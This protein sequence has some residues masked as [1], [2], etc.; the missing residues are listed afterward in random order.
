MV[1]CRL[2]RSGWL[3]LFLGALSGLH[4]PGFVQPPCA[5]LGQQGNAR[6]FC[7]IFSKNRRTGK[8]W[9]VQRCCFRWKSAAGRL[10][11]LEIMQEGCVDQYDA[12]R[13][14]E[15]WWKQHV[16]N[17]ESKLDVTCRHCGHRS[18]STTL[19]S[20]QQGRSPGCF[21]NG[22]VP[23]SGQAGRARCLAILQERHGD[24]YDASRMDEAW[25]KQYVV[26]QLSKLDVTCRRCGHRS[27][28]TTLRSLQQDRS[29]GCFCN[30]AVPWSSL[31]GRARFLEILQER[32]G[33]Q[34]D[35]SRMDEAWWKQHVVN[36]QSKLDVTC[37]HCGHRSISTTLQSL[38][39]DCSP[40]CFCNGGVPWSGQAGRAR[41]LEILQERH[42][43]QYNASRMDEAWWKQHVVH[44]QSKLDVT[45]RR[46]GHRSISTTLRSLQQDRSPGCFCNGA[47]P[48]SSLAG[49]ARFLEILQERHGDQYDASRMDEAW[50][51]QHVVNAQSKLDVTC[52]HCGHRSISTTLR[53]L[54]QGRSPGCFCNGGVPWSGQAG[55][56]RCLAILQERHGDQYD[57]SRMD[58]AWWK[59]YVVNQ[60]SKLD[61]TCRRCGHRSI[62]T[63]LRSLQQDRSPGCFCNGAVP[64]S[65]LAGRARFLEI[66]RERHGDQYDA[67][68]M[69]EAWWKQHVVNGQSKLD[70]TCRRCGHRSISTT[71]RSLQQDCS[72]GCFC[73]GAVPWS[74]QAGRA[75]FLAILQERHGD[76]YDASRM[77]EAWWKQ[78]VVN[79]QSKLDVT[80]RHC[81]HRSISTTLRSLQQGRSPGCFCNGGVPWSGQ[82]GRARCLAIL[83][84]RYGDQYDASRMDEAWWKQHVVH[85]QS[86]LDVTCRRCGHQS[87]S[88]SL[89][90]LQRG[91]S[92][93]CLCSR[94]TEAKL[95]QWLVHEV[96]PTISM[97]V[98]GCRNPDTNYSLPFDFGLSQENIL[99]EL[100]GEIGHFGRGWAKSEDDGGMPFRDFMKEQWAQ[101][102]GK[103]VIRLLQEDVYDDSWDWQGFLKAAIQYVIQNSRPCVLTQ[104]AVQYKSGIYRKLRRTIS[105]RAG[106]F[107]ASDGAS[108]PY[109]VYRMQEK[110]SPVA[111]ILR[112][113][114]LCILCCMAG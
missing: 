45:C 114:C 31:A 36:A 64:W 8:D 50:W 43:D 51:K 17:Q 3:L 46:C 32:H 24:Q 63:A 90:N 67:S 40:G 93:A 7:P 55:R 71:L 100:D 42:G 79:A 76:Q 113:E 105:C 69:D 58:E 29:P 98:P 111:C 60:L 104:A 97:Q 33:D 53:S 88:T 101:R 52:R 27:I 37:R 56:A 44:A 49:R 25:W 30:G 14:D 74:G 34:Y 26:N 19:R 65:S 54:Q 109:L 13:M 16:L 107:Q 70:V 95:R 15:A 38:Q 84:E 112:A 110:Q 9:K 2:Q 23:W 77:D 11:A 91:R 28:S 72:P 59:Q 83:R 81:G 99:I 1:Q 12:S 62:S 85:A 35:A 78:H 80:C 75:R 102:N 68:R 82:A 94:K 18:I 22:G 47:V 41:F 103:T 73:N 20:L 5:G 86:K 89:Q 61:V 39:Q 108:I 57:A 48:W 87:L 96:S 66:L 6:P 21:C 106:Q 10:R 4:L 92:P